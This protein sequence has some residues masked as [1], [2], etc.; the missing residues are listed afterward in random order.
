M[1][2]MKEGKRH[3]GAPLGATEFKLKF[4]EDKV[5]GWCVEIDT[6]AKVTCI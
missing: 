2:V 6:L 1:T 5:E 4:L 3:L